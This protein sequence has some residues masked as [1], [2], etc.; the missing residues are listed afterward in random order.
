MPIYAV[1]GNDKEAAA[2]EQ[3]IQTADRARLSEM[4]WFVYSD[5][6]TARPPTRIHLRAPV[7]ITM[8]WGKLLAGAGL[9]AGLYYL[10]DGRINDL[11]DR[12]TAIEKT[13]ETAFGL[14]LGGGGEEIVD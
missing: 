7:Q 11:G 14:P 13:L 3:K 1:I 12:L 5:L 8:T 2:V 6:A 10:L 9:L 4:A